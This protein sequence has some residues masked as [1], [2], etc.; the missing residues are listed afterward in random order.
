M[1]GLTK[2]AVYGSLRKNL[3]NHYLIADQDFIKKIAVEV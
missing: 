2:V 3:Y 1:A